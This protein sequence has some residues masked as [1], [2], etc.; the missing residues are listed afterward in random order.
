V[1]LLSQ[2]KNRLSSVPT[3]HFTKGRLPFNGSLV[4]MKNDGIALLLPMGLFLTDR[5]RR[6]KTSIT[7]SCYILLRNVIA[8]ENCQGFTNTCTSDPCV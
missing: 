3:E 6:N 2:N 1:L 8:K 7:R 5:E 4:G